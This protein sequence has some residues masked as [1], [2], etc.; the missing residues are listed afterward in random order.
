MSLL[1]AIFGSGTF[2]PEM[3]EV[4]ARMSDLARHHCEHMANLP[5]VDIGRKRGVYWHRV[6]GRSHRVTFVREDEH[7]LTSI[8]LFVRGWS[9]V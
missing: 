7:I 9:K 4:N 8:P 5:V 2:T 6:D 1:N 3:A